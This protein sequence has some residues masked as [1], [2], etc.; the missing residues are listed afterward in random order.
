MADLIVKAA[1][2]EELSDMNVASDFYDALD[3]EVEE[4]LQDAARR[5]DENDRK[6]VQPRDL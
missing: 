5:A 4:L 3:E 1:V 6:T 2:K